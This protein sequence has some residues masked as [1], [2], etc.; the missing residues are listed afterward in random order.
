[1]GHFLPNMPL[2]PYY[3][4]DTLSLE[5]ISFERSS[6]SYEFDTLCFWATQDGRVFTAQDSG[7]SCPTPFEG[8]AGK[9]L[10]DILSGLERVGSVNQ[11]ETTF[12]SWNV[13]DGYNVYL[14]VDDRRKLT[15]WVKKHL[16][17]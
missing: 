12:D 1:M 3:D 17:S 5:I 9:A 13:N 14:G 6:G 16:K 10:D 7:C 15:E 2:N 4:S 11:A 8:Y